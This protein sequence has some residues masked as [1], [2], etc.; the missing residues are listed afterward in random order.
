M[1]YNSLV[2][3]LLPPHRLDHAHTHTHEHTLCS[4]RN[5][6][7][8]CC[9]TG[10]GWIKYTHLAI[11]LYYAGNIPY[12]RTHTPHHEKGFSKQNINTTQSAQNTK[13]ARHVPLRKMFR[14]PSDT[15]TAC[16]RFTPYSSQLME[17]ET[18]TFL[19]T[20]SATYLALLQAP[21]WQQQLTMHSRQMLENAFSPGILE[22]PLPKIGQ[23]GATCS[24]SALL[25]A[26]EASVREWR[27]WLRF[28]MD[29]A[30]SRVANN[31]LFAIVCVCESARACSNCQGRL[32][33]STRRI[34]CIPSSIFV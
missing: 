22:Y 1:R 25:K 13:P 34:R 9:D 12:T 31:L 14:Q 19:D 32:R 27:F 16:K 3:F 11:A 28:R 21:N 33:S 20:Q 23:T 4:H 5:A 24:T 7:A 30:L 10:G 6:C 2:L 8:L 15:E 17:R 29:V 26:L 18:H